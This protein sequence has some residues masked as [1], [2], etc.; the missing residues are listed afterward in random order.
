MLTEIIVV[1]RPETAMLQVTDQSS[2]TVDLAMDSLQLAEF[3]ERVRESIGEFDVGIWMA[4][5][6]R[7]R[8]DTV[9]GLVQHLLTVIPEAP[10]VPLPAVAVSGSMR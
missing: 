7:P 9:G 1:V 3:F 2:L 4:G 10:D 8:G 5:A 6:I